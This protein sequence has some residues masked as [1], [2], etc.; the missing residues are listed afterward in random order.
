MIGLSHKLTKK[1]PE[2]TQK[3]NCKLF[4]FN[5]LKITKKQKKKRFL[6]LLILINQPNTRLI[7]KMQNHPKI[8]P[9]SL[10]TTT[11]PK[12]ILKISS[13]IPLVTPPNLLILQS[14]KTKTTLLSTLS[15][16]VQLINLRLVKIII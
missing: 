7:T 5:N 4:M 10:K 13:I 6:A 12:I 15:N 8:S 16:Q 11:I 14:I 2:K 3:N 9:I 1:K